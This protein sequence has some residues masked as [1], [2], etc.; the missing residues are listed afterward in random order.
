MLLQKIKPEWP[1]RLGF[2]I[3]YLYSGIDLIQHPTAWHWALPY[4]MRE[5]ITSS[6]SLNTYLQAQ[7]MVEIVFAFVLLAWFL[8]RRA[9]WMAA[10]LSVLEFAAILA[11][12]FVPFSEA[13]FLITFRDIGLLGGAFTLLLLMSRH[14]TGMPS[15]MPSRGL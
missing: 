3:M 13:N 14:D 8:P 2:G 7:G 11:L 12:A 15:D 6:V 10:L 5:I 1:L 4:W 9:V